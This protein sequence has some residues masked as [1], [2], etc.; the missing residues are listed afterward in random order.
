MTLPYTTLGWIAL[1]VPG[2]A[3]A[4]AEEGGD[5][6]YVLGAAVANHAAYDGASQR[7]NSLTPV[8]ALQWGK[9]RLTGPNGSALLGFG[10]E[11]AGQGASREFVQSKLWRVGVTLRID[12]GRKSGDADTT[13]GLPDVRRTLR[14]RLYASYRFAPDWD[15]SA[16]VSPDL[17]GRGGGV[18]AGMGVG[19]RFYHSPTTEWTTGAGLNW[20]DAR[21]Q[22][23]Y[24]G[25]PAAYATLER[26]T[27]Q[28]GPG[29]RDAG[30]GLGFKHGL[31][32]QWFLFGSAGVSHLLGPAA[33][34]PLVQRRN[35]SSIS[36]GFAWRS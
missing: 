15:A 21:Y 23:S 17:L 2:L 35:D 11:G 5:V 30:L 19:W 10:R 13:Q 27:Y 24:F 18:Q 36:L 20:A 29:W 1:V 7:K 25:V 26:P 34:S 16:S 6:R 14:G 32:P 22:R 3:L 28:P 31:T 8:W 9:W 33:A 12:S 4:Q